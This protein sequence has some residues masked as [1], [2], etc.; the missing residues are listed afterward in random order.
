MSTPAPNPLRFF[1]AINAYQ[2]TEAIKAAL[3]L[4]LFTAVAESQ[5]AVPVIAERCRA[6]ERGVRILC[7]FL[8]I[9]GFLTKTGER[10]ALT[11]DARAFLVRTSP[12]YLGDSI[13][14]LLSPELVDGFRSLA[15]AVR[16]GGTV[17][18]ANGTMESQHPVWVKFARVMGPVVAVS[19]PALAE[20]ADPRAERPVRVL[21]I[22]AGHGLFGIALARRNRQAHIVAQDWA[23]VLEV[24][25]E[26]ASKAGVADRFTLLPGSAFDVELGSAYDVAL[27]TN[28]L[29]HFD[30]STCERLLRRVARALKPGGVAVT[31]EFVPNADRVTPPPAAKFSA[32]MLATTVAGDAYTFG[33]YDAMFHNAGFSRNTLHPLPESPQSAIV[34]SV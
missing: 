16:R 22:A 19:A 2:Q 1:E 33:E 23:P 25:R 21:D 17:L 12:A 34:S 31:L 28:F 15:D 4:D 24:A 11:P 14:F 3:E 6:A 13:E 32:M 20:L 30:V 18:S 7:D 27:L 8:T 10:F 9:H 26:H 5:G 29:H